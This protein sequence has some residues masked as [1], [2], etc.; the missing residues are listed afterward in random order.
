[1]IRKAAISCKS[2]GLAQALRALVPVHVKRPAGH[3]EQAGAASLAVWM[4]LLTGLSMQSTVQG[5]GPSEGFWITHSLPS[6]PLP[7]GSSQS[8]SQG[9]LPGSPLQA[10]QHAFIL[11]P[12]HAEMHVS[13]ASAH[14]LCNF[15]WRASRLSGQRLQHVPDKSAP[16]LCVR[17]ADMRSVMQSSPRGRSLTGTAS[18]ASPQL[19][20]SCA[21]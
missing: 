21:A 2:A 13:T 8:Q 7:P 15:V 12:E 9:K 19:P 6:F 18:S 3:H 10:C 17:S 1:M 20:S 5:L 16:A 4:M 14:V 11:S